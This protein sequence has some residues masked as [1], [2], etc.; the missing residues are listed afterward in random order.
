[1]ADY[2]VQYRM[3]FDDS[4]AST[5]VIEFCEKD[6]VIQPVPIEIIGDDNPLSISKTNNEENKF[7][8]IIETKVTIKYVVRA[9]VP[10]DPNPKQF[11]II[12]EDDWLINIYKDGVIWWKGFIVPGSNGYPWVPRPFVCSINVSDF[13]FCK[14]QP[15]DLNDPDNGLFDYNYMKVGEFINR[16]LFH[17][18]GYDNCILNILLSKTPAA[19]SGQPI[20]E[21]YVHADAFYDFDEGADYSFNALQKFVRSIGARMF[22]EQ[23]VYWIQFIED[24]GADAQTI[25]RLTPDNLSGILIPYT[26]YTSILGNAAGDN[27]VYMNRTQEVII[28]N[29]LKQQ[30]FIYDLK[31]INQVKNFDW[32]TN[33]AA[34]YERWQTSIADTGKF[35]RSGSG[36]T[37]DPYR[38]Q[39]LRR[40][41]LTDNLQTD[42]FSYIP[43]K[44]GQ[45]IEVTIKNKAFLTLG[46]PSDEDFTLTTSIVIVLANVLGGDVYD[47]DSAGNWVQSPTDPVIP[48]SATPG[49][50]ASTTTIQSKPIPVVPGVDLG[51]IIAISGTNID[52]EPPP[53]SEYYTELYPVFIGVFSTRYIQYIEKI[54]NVSKYSYKPDKQNMFFLDNQDAAYS[55]NLFYYEEPD[56]LP[57][58]ARNWTNNKN[59]D[60]IA[61]KQYGDEQA[62]PTQTVMGTFRS[63]TL[64]FDQCV[65]LR[66]ESFMKTVQIRD[67][68]N[69]KK[70][71]HDMMFM[72]LLEEGAANLTY[73]V[74]PVT[75]KDKK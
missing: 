8:P 18:V 3:T 57:F 1:M 67:K 34:P 74:T 50:D 30:D 64:H 11:I 42:E 75:S 5:W 4:L 60:E 17:S 25:I 41:L 13:S 66:D 71:E 14:T 23:G 48:F 61:V 59:I 49:K 10:S 47:M 35:I 6:G 53:G 16:T 72:Q 24:I 22:H 68:Y 63:N 40:A 38:V 21:A 27:V 32:R 12:E 39:I 73:T 36:T 19:L 43:V 46:S 20:T 54:T 65:L 69:V 2:N 45:I 37:E 70:C 31:A 29:S 33:T 52:K 26:D 7:T 56:F 55:N 62:I 15:M 9:D 28:N 51:I 44:P 58:P